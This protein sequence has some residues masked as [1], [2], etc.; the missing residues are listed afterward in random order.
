MY[1]TSSLKQALLLWKRLKLCL[2]SKAEMACL[3][4]SKHWHGPRILT[5]YRTGG[6]MVEGRGCTLSGKHREKWEKGIFN[7][8]VL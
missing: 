8:R 1:F 2:C 6:Q 5:L 4:W 3:K 7:T